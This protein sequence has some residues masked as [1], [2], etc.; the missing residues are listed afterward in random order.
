MWTAFPTQDHDWRPAASFANN[1]SVC[2]FVFVES[3]FKF[4]AGTHVQG[5]YL[6][7]KEGRENVHDKAELKLSSSIL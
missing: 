7:T 6:A 1:R 5:S 2:L 3:F 4:V